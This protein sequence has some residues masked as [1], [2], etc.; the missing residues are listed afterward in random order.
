MSV[1][2]QGDV[3]NSFDVYKNHLLAVSSDHTLCS[4]DFRHRKTGVRSEE[5]HGDLLSIVVTER[6]AVFY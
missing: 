5:M 1:K 3:I 6:L 2:E 4:Y